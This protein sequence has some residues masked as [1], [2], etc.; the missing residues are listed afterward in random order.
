M[1]QR[2]KSAGG[3]GVH[4]SPAGFKVVNAGLHLSLYQAASGRIC[5]V[6]I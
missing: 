1:V 6:S 5:R 3:T 4:I 2:G